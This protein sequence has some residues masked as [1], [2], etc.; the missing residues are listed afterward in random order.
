MTKNSVS[1]IN[2]QINPSLF[3]W[4]YLA[5]KPILE[6][7]KS[8][9]RLAEKE[10]AKKI[11][12]LGCGMKPYESLFSFADAFIGFDT[13]NNEKVDAV[14]FNWNLP[15][16]D[17]EFDA[18]IST[19]VLEHTAK[20]SETIEEIKRVVKNG[21]LIFISVPLVFPEHGIPYDYYR[22]TSFGI[23]EVFRGFDVLKIIPQGGYISTLIRIINVFLNYLPGS[24]F[25][26]PVFM[27][28]NVIA[29]FFDNL[30]S[31]LIKI[32]GKKADKLKQIYYGMPENYIAVMRN[33]K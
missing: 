2:K 28:N 9:A 22:F 16:Q 24:K 14:G 32:L 17:S 13:Q 8:F 29:V 7:I 33:K 25:L 4:G 5:L 21:G 31:F 1:K 30:F 6:K 26:F 19:Q 10:N 27:I 3:N 12:D 20:V 11:L 23:R 15:F 18:L